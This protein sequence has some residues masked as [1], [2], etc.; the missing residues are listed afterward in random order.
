MTTT[1][2][3]EK[4]GATGRERT[5]LGL[6]WIKSRCQLELAALELEEGL[7][8]VTRVYKGEAA[9]SGE[10]PSAVILCCD[11]EDDIASEGGIVQAMAP[12]ATVLVF[13]P[14]VDPP[15]ARE[16]LRS[17]A[18]GLLHAGMSAKQIRRAVSVA[19]KGETV[20][21]RKLFSM[22]LDEQRRTDPNIVL[23]PRQLEILQFAAEGFTNAQIARNLYLAEATVKQHL[24]AAYK[25]L[26][27]HKRNEAAEL[28]LRN[29]GA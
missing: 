2:V 29:A 15:L 10:A 23:R 20:L 16:V 11:Q 12:A 26:G 18:S 28:L 14:F 27:V 1:N 3:L 22:W 19:L 5:P 24:R 21:P 9:P 25:K 4:G 6:V 17:G 8:A 7:S 13:A